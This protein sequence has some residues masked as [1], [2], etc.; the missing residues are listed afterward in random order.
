[1]FGSRVIF[2]V[3]AMV[4]RPRRDER[5]TNASSSARVFY[6]QRP[7]QVDQ[8]YLDQPLDHAVGS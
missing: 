3:I 2:L 7:V 1:M 8:S 4:V 6:G 5:D